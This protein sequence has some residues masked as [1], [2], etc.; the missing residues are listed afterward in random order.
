MPRS[1]WDLSSLTRDWTR[2]P[3]IVTTGLPGNSLL[4][5]YG[6]M[7]AIDWV[8]RESPLAGLQTVL[9]LLCLHM[10]KRERALLSL[11]LLIRAL[12]LS[13]VPTLLIS[14]NQ[15]PSQRPTSE[16]HH[17]GDFN[18]WL[19]GGG[20]NIQPTPEGHWKYSINGSNDRH[21]NRGKCALLLHSPV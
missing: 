4:F 1:I 5:V 2:V 14:L 20:T 18:M 10:A 6:P 3:Y 11:P 15:I 17:T 13:R 9:F 21:T 7:H 19:L 8:P 12:I 16:N